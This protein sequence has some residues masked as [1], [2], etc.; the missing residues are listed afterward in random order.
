[1]TYIDSAYSTAKVLI[2]DLQVVIHTTGYLDNHKP[3]SMWFGPLSLSM[4]TDQAI[5]MGSALIRAAHHHRA[6]SMEC[7]ATDVAGTGVAP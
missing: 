7:A 3:V 5:D 6:V 2:D 4:S 1:M